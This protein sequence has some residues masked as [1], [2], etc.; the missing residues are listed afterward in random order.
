MGT[1]PSGR[2]SLK[3][4]RGTLSRIQD[5]SLQKPNK[6]LPLCS[7]RE[8]DFLRGEVFVLREESPSLYDRIQERNLARQYDLLTNCT[9]IGIIQRVRAFDKYMLWS[10]N[11]AAVANISQF[12]GRFREEPIYLQGHAPPH[13][14]QVNHLMDQFIST[15]QENWFAWSETVLASYVLWRLNW[16][17]PFIEGNGRT[18]RAACYY[19]LCA[20][21]RG[22]PGGKIIV[23]ERIRHDREPYYEALR[24]ADQA[25]HN[26]ELR[27]PKME[28]YLAR[29]LDEQVMDMPLPSSGETQTRPFGDN[30]N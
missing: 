21:F 14:S 8:A 29:L 2:A 27:F 15:V 1:L 6:T 3:R 24:E 4:Q 10:L 5:L 25:W 30:S 19:T 17:H 12:G 23:P 7:D 22:L 28:A 20:K 11:A 16:I 18:A 13:F 26:G 9:E